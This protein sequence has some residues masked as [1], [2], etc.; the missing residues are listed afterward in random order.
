MGF[1]ILFINTYIFWCIKSVNSTSC[2][3]YQ[4][5]YFVQKYCGC[6]ETNLGSEFNKSLH[7]SFVPRWH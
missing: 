6:S 7:L 4:D 1:V 5:I 2:V 3:G